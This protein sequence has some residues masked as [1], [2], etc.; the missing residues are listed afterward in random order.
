[1]RP[2]E[3]YRFETVLRLAGLLRY[4]LFRVLVISAVV[5]VMFSHDSNALLKPDAH[6]SAA[7]E[8]V[9]KNVNGSHILGRQKRSHIIA[10]RLD[11]P[12]SIGIA[13]L[14]ADL[15]RKTEIG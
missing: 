5:D 12:R 7:T 2:V 11:A 10:G 15:E 1:M 9:G 13:P 4:E 8:M 14:T 6:P 3:A